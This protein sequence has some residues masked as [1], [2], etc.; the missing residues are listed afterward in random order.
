MTLE[1]LVKVMGV[2]RW[3]DSQVW[4]PSGRRSGVRETREPHFADAR[5]GRCGRTGVIY[6]GAADGR[7]AG[8]E[9]A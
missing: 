6:I 2:F 5:D 1:T 8:G 3:R 7:L 4:R 9:G